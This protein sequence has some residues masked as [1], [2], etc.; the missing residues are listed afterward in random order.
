MCVNL[1]DLQWP[2]GLADLQ[3]PVGF[4]TAYERVARAECWCRRIRCRAL[5]NLLSES[6]FL[7]CSGSVIA[8]A[9]SVSHE[10]ENPRISQ[11]VC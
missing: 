5:M 8:Y 1:A 7:A 3:W 11:T 2:V 9:G 4:D 10:N 6:S